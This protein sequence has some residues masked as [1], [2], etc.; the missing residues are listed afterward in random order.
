[1]VHGD[2]SSS[3]VSH[4][5]LRKSMSNQWRTNGPE[6]LLSTSDRSLQPVKLSSHTPCREN[7]C[8]WT[9]WPRRLLFSHRWVK[10]IIVPPLPCHWRKTIQLWQWA[11]YWG[12]SPDASLIDLAAHEKRSDDSCPGRARN[13]AVMVFFWNLINTSMLTVL[14]N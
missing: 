7:T 8:T 5:G 9:S 13:D 1:M 14:V 10:D 2:D 4:L 11:A 12:P 6:V 3:A